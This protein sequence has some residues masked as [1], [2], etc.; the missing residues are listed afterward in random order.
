MPRVSELT[1]RQKAAVLMIALGPEVSAGVLKHLRED[2][3]E[4]L[5]VEIAGM[6]RVFPEV[7]DKVLEE[8]SEMYQANE[9]ISQGGVDY[10]REVL[11]KAL[12]ENRAEAILDRLT[13]SLQVRP[14]DFARRTDAAQ[15]LSFIQN[16]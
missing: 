11:S 8:F 5:T 9:F 6:R 12:G 2:E 7:K 10:A 15:V 13:S 1:G 16:E 3:I 4:D 14:F